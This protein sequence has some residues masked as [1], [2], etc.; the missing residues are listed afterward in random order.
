MK[1]IATIAENSFYIAGG[2]LRYDAPCYVERRADQELYEALR[3]GKFC[4]VLT[5]R[6]MGKSSLIMNVGNRLR[7]D[8]I[9]VVMLD[10]T[11]IGKN[12][13]AE[14]WYDGILSK[15][16]Q[17]LRLEDEL[18]EFWF[19]HQRFGPLQRWMNAITEVVLPRCPGQLVIFVDEIDYV[20]NLPFSTDEFFAGIRE[21]YNRRAKEPEL[22]RLTFCLSGV[23]SPSDLIRDAGMTPFNIGQRIELHDF[24][25]SEAAKLARG[26]GRGEEPGARLLNRILYWSGG[27]PYLTQRLC[28]VVAN[29]PEVSSPRGVDR[30]CEEMFF[31]RRAREEDDNLSFVQKCMLWEK[32]D[33]AGLLSLHEQVRR[34]RRVRNDETN[35]LVSALQLS[36]IT[37][38]EDGHLRTRNRIYERV[39]DGEWV[40]E[41]MPGAELRRQRAAFRR[42]LL[43]A[44]AVA[45]AIIAVIT[46]LALTAVKQRNRAEQQELANRRL[47][48][49]AHM[50]QAQQAWETANIGR[51]EELLAAYVPKP[52]QEDLRGFEWYYLWRFCHG[53][54]FTLRHTEPV[55]SITF[56]PDG[57][58]LASGS[59][60]RTVKLWD[61]A[62]GQELA[63]LEGHKARITSIAFSPD[64]KKLASGS[65]DRTV[66]LWDVTTGQDFANFNEHT[67][68][69]FCVA[70]SPDGK[71]LASGSEDRTVKLWDVVTTQELATL[72]G[73]AHQVLSVIFSPDGKKLASGSRDHTVKLWD[74]ATSRELATLKRHADWVQS[75]AFSPD[76][77]RL[78]SG[79]WDFTVKLW[80]MITK[81]ELTTLKGHASRV[82][83]IAFSPDGKRLA[84]GSQDHTIKFWD[85]VSG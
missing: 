72:K 41:N 62:T 69:V 52:G 79:S 22:E 64:G 85:V 21:L 42:G 49:A 68:K 45:A 61:V 18:E 16:G 36:G 53:D 12:L 60:D 39:F 14:Q 15:I 76:S 19:A 32:M 26:L 37:R 55:S 17:E 84:S 7:K 29:E 40:K 47:L 82:Y 20:L 51:M 83:S 27:Q 1:A 6:Q 65:W 74:V 77:K 24:T 63:T 25:E 43:R 66:K 50:N 30:I 46:V 2:T 44:S 34:G 4:Y 58:K 9:S 28:Q 81:Q 75:V 8:G 33:V 80:D 59:W 11:G 56:S 54:L 3:R 67:S 10:L 13:S 31:T 71:K 5:S 48:Y 78:A 23:A 35:P 57:K 38:D 73:H 70:F